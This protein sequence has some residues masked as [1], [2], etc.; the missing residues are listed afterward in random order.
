LTQPDAIP[1]DPQA[2]LARLMEGNARFA[3]DRKLNQGQDTV[4]RA[5]VA[6]GQRPFAA[7]LGCSDSR[8]PVEVVFDQGLGDLFVVRVAGNTAADASVVGSIEFA[9]AELGCPLVLVL[10]HEGCGAVAAAVG[11]AVGGAEPPG[12]I[13]PAIAPI[14]AVAERVSAEQQGLRSDEL[15]ARCVRA[16]V[17]AVAASLA[18]GSEIVAGRVEA[19]AAAI[20]GAVYR[21]ESGEVELLDPASAGAAY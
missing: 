8:V 1:P 5:E 13:G 20:A 7:I 15:A 21:L 3:A 2:A 17:G 11:R 18:E 14:A 12:S 9:L 10:G 19:G 4:R 16:N 6:A